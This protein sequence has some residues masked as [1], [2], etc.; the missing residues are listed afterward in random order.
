MALIR[1]VAEADWP[2]VHDLVV[3]VAS[4]GETYALDVPADLAATRELWTGEHVVV[5]VDGD[6]VLGTAKAGPVRPAQG[7]H[8]GTASFMVGSAAR[9]LGVGR[10]LGEH[11]VAWHREQGYRAIQFN[12][13]VATN[14]AALRLWRSLGFVVIGTVPAAFRRP[15]GDYAD[16][17]VMHLDLLAQPVAVPEGKTR[18]R[19]LAVGARCFAERGWHQTSLHD[20]AV[21]A[22]LD[23]VAQERGFPSKAHLLWACLVEVVLPPHHDLVTALEELRL[24][25]L[26]DVEE[27]LD[28]I[29]SLL[30]DILVRLAPLT[31][32]ANEA[33][34]ADPDFAAMVRGSDLRRVAASRRMAQLVARREQPAPGAADLVHALMT[35][36]TYLS[37]V[38]A[39]W[40]MERYA[41]WLRGAIDHAVNGCEA[42][43]PT[44]SRVAR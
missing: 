4:A 36:E 30:C 22:G 5:C 26:L 21:I 37:F 39:G 24:H 40:S 35:S 38:R 3:E 33:A 41:G 43:G 2:Q 17:C 12:A 18:A 1:P 34:A 8:V 9:G 11:V 25:E 32:A 6:R 15:S 28:R 7:A 44:T 29:V 14:V 16:L 27:R 23:P 20:I 10:A 13:V 42:A 19:L 31:P